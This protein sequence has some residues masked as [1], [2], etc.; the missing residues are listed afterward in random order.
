M[1]LSYRGPNK[2][3]VLLDATGLFNPHRVRGVGRYVSGLVSGFQ[4]ILK[5][6]SEIELRCLEQISG[7]DNNG[8]LPFPTIQ[9]RRPSYPSIRLQWLWNSFLLAKEVT[10]TESF[11]FHSTDY[12]GIPIS[13]KFKTIATLYDLIPLVFSETYLKDKPLDIRLGYKS[14]L[15]RYQR[16]DHIISIS[17][18]TKKDA[19]QFLG[20][21][22]DKI[23]VVPLA[24]DKKLF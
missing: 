1:N 10:K 4:S 7:N 22:E 16:T 8:F 2:P 3:R 17:E 12:N 5:D 23:T 20:I 13:K 11:L 9:N 15:K 14:I 21:S 24:F 18:A 19:V 6:D